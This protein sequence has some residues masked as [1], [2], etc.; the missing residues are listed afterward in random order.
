MP[1]LL[2]FSLTTPAGT[3][4]YN[5]TTEQIRLNYDAAEPLSYG[6]KQY[7]NCDTCYGFSMLF[8]GSYK[9]RS[10]DNEEQFEIAKEEFVTHFN[11]CHKD[12]MEK[13][14][15][16]K[17]KKFKKTKATGVLMCDMFQIIHPGDTVYEYDFSV[18]NTTQCDNMVV[19][20]AIHE[21][22]RYNQPPPWQVGSR[23]PEYEVISVNPANLD[24]NARFR[25]SLLE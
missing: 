23:T 20:T 21:V 5:G 24:R 1:N 11:K 7:D 25:A 17:E 3:F 8:G 2:P 4:E 13:R 16:Y 22:S 10:I 6:S 19:G 15:E 9:G 14:P 12:I 18:D